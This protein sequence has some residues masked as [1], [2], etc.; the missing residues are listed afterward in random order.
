MGGGGESTN[1]WERLVKQGCDQARGREGVIELERGQE[2]TRTTH[3]YPSVEG[4]H[5]KMSAGCKHCQQCDWKFL[6]GVVYVYGFCS[7]QPQ[8]STKRT[9]TVHIST[10]RSSP[11]VVQIF[12][13]INSTVILKLHF[14]TNKTELY[15]DS[16][17]LE[18][19]LDLYGF[20]VLVGMFWLF[21]THK[22]TVS[23]CMQRSNSYSQLKEKEQAFSL[24]CSRTL[25]HKR[26]HVWTWQQS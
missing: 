16:L 11:S 22:T 24:S 14:L 23:M 12:K 7:W 8:W 1:Y 25:N 3:T 10:K 5:V 15:C 6:T 2:H 17:V 21:Y 18:R 9:H 4:R 26:Y 19:T 13:F 20:N